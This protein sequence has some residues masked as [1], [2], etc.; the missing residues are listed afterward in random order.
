MCFISGI[1]V[2]LAIALDA[3]ILKHFHGINLVGSIAPVTKKMQA[4]P[5]LFFLQENIISI[6]SCLLSNK[7]LVEDL[8]GICISGFVII[9]P[10][11]L[12][13]IAFG[14]MDLKYLRL[15]KYCLILLHT[16]MSRE[17]FV[18]PHTTVTIL[19]SRLF[20]SGFGFT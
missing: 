12:I 14:F 20:C 3:G 6:I 13:L 18:S 15:F 16:K 7:Y 1:M 8:C 9:Q 5:L 4:S 11:L 17:L 2:S 19:N 10:S